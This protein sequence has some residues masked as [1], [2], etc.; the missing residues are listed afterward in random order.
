MI[1]SKNVKWGEDVTIDVEVN[2]NLKLNTL[3]CSCNCT[4]PSWY[5]TDTGYTITVKTKMPI[6]DSR[7]NPEFTVNRKCTITYINGETEVV[8]YNFNLNNNAIN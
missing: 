5:K 4:S 1:V 6:Y 3:K 7:L 2:T 8:N